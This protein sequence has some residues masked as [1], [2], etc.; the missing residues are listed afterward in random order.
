VSGRVLVA[1]T[2]NVFFGDDGFGVEVAQR[3]LRR[4]LPPG[5]RVVDFGVRAFDLACALDTADAA[6]LVDTFA[7]GKPPG[8]LIVVEPDLEAPDLS[9]GAPEDSGPHGLDPATVLRLA[10][11][12]RTLPP[13]LLLVGCEPETLGGAH[14]AMGLSPAVTAAVENAVCLVEALATDL[15]NG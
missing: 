2:G 10:R 6:I 14:G 1:G 4:N 5:V 15:I 3:L 13:R 7:H 12:M 9:G 8:D 11:R